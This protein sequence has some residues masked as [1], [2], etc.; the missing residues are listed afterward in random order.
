MAR[1]PQAAVKRFSCALVIVVPFVLAACDSQP[2]VVINFNH[3][4]ATVSPRAIGMAETGYQDP[5]V[6]ANDAVEQQRLKLLGLGLVRMDLVYQVSG[7]PTSK[8]VCGSD[9]CDTDPSGDQW[10]AAIRGAGAQP[11][12][13]VNTKS[14]VD[15]A[16]MVRHFNVDPATK[17]P[18]PAR[19]NYVRYWIIGNEPNT[20]GYSS[21]SYS[22]YFNADYDA[23]KAVDPNIKIGGPAVAWYDVM[24][25]KEFLGASGNRVDFVDFHGYPQQ[26]T[27]DGDVEQLFRWAA[28]TGNDVRNLRAIIAAAVPARAS[29]IGVEVGEWSLN[30]GGNAQGDTNFNTVWTADVI[31]HILQGGGGSIYFGTKGNAIKWADG[32]DTD[33]GGHTVFMHLDDP[34]APYH[35]HGMFTGE[36]L[37]RPFGQKMV[38]AVT[39]L[40]NVD[41]FASNGAKNIVVV[42]KDKTASRQAVFSLI[43]VPASATVNVWQKNQNVL[44][45][46]PPVH[47]GVVHVNGGTF[48]YRLPAMSVTTFVI[49]Q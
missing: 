40:P 34:K 36:G 28:S 39:S 23:M 11:E 3:V 24:W 10:I 20:S 2:N 21:S 17:R 43:G 33:D 15:A 48:S 6:L 29:G 14:F 35:G 13:I 30:W 8:I 38:S 37:F 49:A 44:F 19:P 9:G 5:N 32:F 16:N 27:S 46:D 18:D 1:F 42:N 26:G 47:R 22:S 7:D 12:L 31:G 41:V 25:I 45:R 4:T